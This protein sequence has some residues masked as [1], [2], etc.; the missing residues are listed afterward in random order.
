MYTRCEALEIYS[1]SM[2]VTD[3]K[4]VVKLQVLFQPSFQNSYMNFEE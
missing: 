1:K 4:K 3:S 2:L